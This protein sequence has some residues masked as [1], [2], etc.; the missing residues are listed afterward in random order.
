MI[1]LARFFPPARCG[2][3]NRSRAGRGALAFCRLGHE[4]LE[5]RRVLSAVTVT[6]NLDLVNGDTTSIAALL[7]NDG[8]DGIALREA[9]EAANNTLGA[10]EITFDFG[11][12][13]PETILLGLGE[14]E[15]TDDVTITG[16][17]PD[18]MTI[19]AQQNSRI[20]NITAASGDFTLAGMTITGGRTTGNFERGGAIS[21]QFS[22][23]VDIDGCRVTDSSTSGIQ[24]W[25]GGIFVRHRLSISASTI[26]GNS[27]TGDDAVGGGVFARY[28]SLRQSTVSGNSTSGADADGGGIFSAFELTIEDSTISGNSVAGAGT[29]GGG[30]LSRLAGATISRSTIVDNHVA[31]RCR[32]W[33]DLDFGKRVVYRLDH[34]GQYRGR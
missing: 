4:P 15:I 31:A 33:W 18:L 19:D 8:G 3:G 22:A 11:H 1:L 25:G 20:F 26:S 24:S 30:V 2:A 14:L 17:G 21:S 9:I 16:D 12:D 29:M 23:V 7:A 5:D 6:N 32:H 28:L 34:R 13:G 27:T 10:D